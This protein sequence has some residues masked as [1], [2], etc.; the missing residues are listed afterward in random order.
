MMSEAA[1]RLMKRKDLG[2]EFISIIKTSKHIKHV[3]IVNCNHKIIIYQLN[4][5]ECYD[6]YLTDD[7]LDKNISLLE[8]CDNLYTTHERNIQNKPLMTKGA[9]VFYR[10]LFGIIGNNAAVEVFLNELRIGLV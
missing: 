2:E 8:I 4:G 9:Y 1:Q 7:A 3:Q 5:A 10:R 6:V